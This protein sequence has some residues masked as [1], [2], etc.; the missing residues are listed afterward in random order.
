MT[1]VLLW[2]CV[3][4]LQRIYLM[5]HTWKVTVLSCSVRSL[6]VCTIQVKSK[7]YTI[8]IYQNV[9][10]ELKLVFVAHTNRWRETEKF[11]QSAFAYR[12]LT[13]NYMCGTEFPKWNIK[14]IVNV[15]MFSHSHAQCSM[16]NALILPFAC[17]WLL[18]DVVCVRVL[19]GLMLPLPMLK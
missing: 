7:F 3:T 4:A 19:S 14:F 5:V 6:C 15:K 1:S 12:L 11:R 17:C 9:Y 18:C 13:I 2:R 8:W 16:L 10:D